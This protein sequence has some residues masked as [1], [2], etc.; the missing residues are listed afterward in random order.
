MGFRKDGANAGYLTL[1]FCGSAH[2]FWPDG[3]PIPL[4][5]QKLATLALLALK[6]PVRR[7]WLAQLLYPESPHKTA[8]NTFRKF[9]SDM[10]KALGK[11]AL[12]GDK[13]SLRLGA[14]VKHNLSD[15]YVALQ[16]GRVDI[17]SELL[18]GLSFP[19]EPGLSEVIEAE[20]LHWRARVLD[21]L[22]RLAVEASASGRLDLAISFARRL[23]SEQP[24][25]DEAV[26]LLMESL[27]QNGERAAALQEFEYFKL[28]LWDDQGLAPED[29]TVR[30]ALRISTT[31]RPA[32][33]F[34]R[35]LP[36][37]LRRPPS[38]VGREQQ[39]AKASKRLTQGLPVLITGPS[40]VGKTRLFEEVAL[41]VKPAVELM[42]RVDDSLSSLELLTQIARQ[43]QTK[44]SAT[45]ASVS[46]NEVNSE[47]YVVLQWLA[48]GRRT[49]PPQ[50]LMTA[51]RI[52]VL[53]RSVLEAAREWGVELIA[54]DNLQFA[55]AE[56]LDL[57]GPLMPD[58]IR[59]DPRTPN[60]LVSGREPLPLA[61]AR[62]LDQPLEVGEPSQALIHLQDWSVLEVAEFLRSMTLQGIDPPLWAT[63]LHGHCG[64]QPMALLRLLRTLHEAGK[65]GSRAPPIELPVPNDYTENVQRLLGRLDDRAR[66]LAFLAAIAGADFDAALAEAVLKCDATA[67]LCPWYA[68]ERLGIL[69][70]ESFSH[71]LVRQAVLAAVPAA[72]VPA[73]H[74]KIAGA[75]TMENGG[76]ER[77]AKHW[78]RAGEPRLAAIDT[79]LAAQDLIAAGLTVPARARLEAAQL[80]Y[81]EAGAIKEA[82]ECRVYAVEATRGSVAADASLAEA[83]QLL[84]EPLS[85]IQRVR[86]LCVLA[87]RLVDEQMPEALSVAV[88]A[89]EGAYAIREQTLIVRARVRESAARRLVGQTAEAL[90]ILESLESGFHLLEPRE[91]I[92][93]KLRYAQAL[94]S[95]GR[96]DESISIHL[97]LLQEVGKQGDPYQA[98]DIAN[99]ASVQCM[100]TNRLH[101]G[102]KLT[103]Q[104]IELG[105]RAG[106]E[107]THL[108][109]D[110]MNLVSL[111]EDLAYFS[112]ALALG[113]R[114]LDDMRRIGHRWQGPCERI[115][116]GVYL[117]LGQREKALD[118]LGELPDSAPAWQRA[119]RRAARAALLYGQ[120][121]AR[122]KALE[123]AMSELTAGEVVLGPDIRASLLLEV[124][125]ASS[126]DV[127]LT[128]AIDCQ[129]AATD[130]QH[131]PLFR[132]ACM[133]EVEAAFAL[134]KIEHARKAADRLAAEMDRNWETFS[135]YPPE[136]WCILVRAWDAIGDVQKAK[137][138]AHIAVD[139]I[140]GRATDHVPADLQA[141]FRTAN[142][143]NR[144]L[145][146]RVT[147][148]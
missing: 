64:G 92:E 58:P 43:I 124:A 21:A 44:L 120:G 83:S 26:R 14:V 146:G 109:V 105:R 97:M 30:Q 76:F 94:G 4:A 85:A 144:E 137:E 106:I 24:L 113:T 50:G 67:L 108:L 39:L 33:Q 138:W 142:P 10:R 38:M 99:S 51:E 52:R 126:P 9:V 115:L 87:D 28:R 66:M 63:A 40:G 65:L 41:R 136:V 55:D 17:D 31:A 107:S 116:S 68:L 25:G 29:Q 72:L 102:L 79:E 127:A 104:A 84:N 80:L 78:R 6:G 56:S 114:I 125:R 59:G 37:P 45:P 70:G 13:V 132:R 98:A 22:R 135:L 147:Q 141:S 143:F 117:Q 145:L 54:I 95:F 1:H 81:C 73:M 100:F 57:L 60:W 35:E 15:P 16:S 89:V 36:E 111:F 101:D 2:A 20:R 86:V 71:E 61:L 112:E 12:E 121:P 103:E 123:D 128:G 74:R 90:A 77:R 48:S 133:C 96:R 18:R 140:D 148:R 5:S 62:W 139:W 134:G 119:Y 82:L 122:L 23:V 91:Q 11:E 49:V 3:T 19:D 27:E 53:L 88:Q 42:L 75:L 118:L 32:E 8:L 129:R 131:I 110:S 34:S 130:L 69:R 47:A 46:E 7:V 93:A